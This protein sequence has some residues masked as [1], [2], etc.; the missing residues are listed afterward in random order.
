VP[1]WQC[2]DSSPNP[3]TAK[4]LKK[5]KKKK[6]Y[7][8]S[9][10]PLNPSFLERDGVYTQSNMVLS[11]LLQPF[12]EP[13]G[14]FFHTLSC[15]NLFLVRIKSGK[16]ERSSEEYTRNYSA[17]TGISHYGSGTPQPTW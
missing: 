2:G 14:H 15:G 12:L 3:S 13:L 1:A 8:R 7:S 17:Q 9:A 10:S 16:W 11:Q 6:G 4:K 5:K